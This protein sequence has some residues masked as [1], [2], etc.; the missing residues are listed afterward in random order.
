M[1]RQP[2]SLAELLRPTLAIAAA[3]AESAKVQLRAEIVDTAPRVIVDA[4]QAQ[5]ALTFLLTDAIAHTEK[6]G[7]V[8]V[9]ASEVDSS[10]VRIT[11]VRRPALIATDTAVPLEMRLAR[12]LLEAQGCTIEVTGSST[13]I[14]L[15]AESASHVER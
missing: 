6:G 13:M 1:V 9:D 11:I 4:V 2:T 14:G 8:D 7:D 12:R 3:R 15:P 5:E 10:H